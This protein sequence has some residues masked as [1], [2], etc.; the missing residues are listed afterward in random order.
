VAAL[1][2]AALAIGA[3]SG[4][5]A[6]QIGPQ[7]VVLIN[8]LCAQTLR[9]NEEDRLYGMISLAVRATIR[10]RGAEFRPDVIDDAVQDSLDAMI[11]DCPELTEADEAKRVTMAVEMISDATTKVLEDAKQ[12]EKLADKDSPY[13]KRPPEKLTAADLSQELSSHEIDQWLESLPPRQ[14]A[15]SLF[16]YASDVTPQEI[17]AAVGE[18]AGALSRQ[19]AASKLDLMRIFREEWAEQ[20]PAPRGGPAMQFREAGEG[21]AALMQSTSAAPAVASAPPP[22]ADVDPAD[23]AAATAPRTRQ[24]QRAAEDGLLPSLRVTGISD[25]L[26]SGWS[27]LATGRNLP[28]GQRIAIAEPIVLEPDNAN[29]KRMLVVEIAEMGDPNAPVRHFL[30]KAYAIDAE[31]EA[32]GLRDS[33]H[34]GAA[35]ANEEAKRTLANRDLSSIEVARCLWKDFGTGQDPG[36]CR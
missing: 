1:F 24:R 12:A 21:F 10:Y 20:L 31:K 26:Y 18:P 35:F 9:T 6:A 22:A 25:D 13:P 2:G 27:L 17:A 28:R 16:L 19:F 32:A 33:F 30:L 23:P 36:L 4:Q 29:G 34:V 8:R 11:E 7:T 15:L 3:G 5:A 14:R